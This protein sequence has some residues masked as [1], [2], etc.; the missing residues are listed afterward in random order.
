MLTRRRAAGALDRRASRRSGPARAGARSPRRGGG[1]SPRTTPSSI[2]SGRSSTATP[3]SG[4]IVRSPDGSTSETMTPFPSGSTGPERARPRVPCSRE[5]A[6]VPA[7][8]A[9]R[10]P[11]KREL[12]PRAATQA[13][14]FAAW[15]PGRSTIRE[16]ASAPV[17][18]GC[19][20]RTITSS[21]RSPRQ[22]IDIAYDPCMEPSSRRARIGADGAGDEGAPATGARAAS[23]ARS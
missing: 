8:S 1:R 22:K 14:T 11:T 6:S 16:V 19:S 3:R 20:R 12:P 10:L 23:C 5:A 21:T 15:P 2:S 17:A 9:P 4:H 18:S 13:A 7:S